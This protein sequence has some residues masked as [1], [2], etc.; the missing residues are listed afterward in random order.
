M[1]LSTL[2]QV[3]YQPMQVSPFDTHSETMLMFFVVLFLYATATAGE[4]LMAGDP[5]YLAVASNIRLLVSVLSSILLLLILVPIMGWVAFGMWLCFAFKVI[6]DSYEVVY[7]LLREASLQ[8][9]DMARGIMAIVR[10]GFRTGNASNS[11]VKVPKCRETDL[12]KNIKG[13]LSFIEAQMG[14]IGLGP[15]Q[16]I[17]PGRFLFFSSSSCNEEETRDQRYRK[18][19]KQQTRKETKKK[20]EKK[21]QTSMNY[22]NYH[23]QRFQYQY[24]QYPQQQQQQQVQYQ[25]HST[26]SY[27]STAPLTTEAYHYHKQPQYLLH[28]PPPVSGHPPGIP[29]PPNPYYPPVEN[30]QQPNPGLD[31]QFWRPTQQ[32]QRGQSTHKDGS[33]SGGRTFRGHGQGHF[34]HLSSTSGGHSS[35][36]FNRKGGQV[37]GKHLKPHGASLTQNSAPAPA[38]GAA[39]LI[40]PFA[41]MSGHVASQVSAAPPHVPPRM[42]W[43]DL[44]KVGCK[45]E[46]ILEQHKNGKK[47]KRKLSK[48][49]ELQNQNQLISEYSNL[50]MPSSVLKLE[51]VRSEKSLASKEAENLPET[52]ACQAVSSSNMDETDPQRGTAMKS[53][54]SVCES[55][56]EPANKL[57]CQFEKRGRGVKRKKSGAAGRKHART[58]V[59]PSGP[60]D[61]AKS[62]E[63]T[64]FICELCNVRCESQTGFDHHLAGKKH[65]KKS[66]A[67]GG[68]HARTDAGPSGPVDHAKSKKVTPFV[69][70]LCN[71]RCESQ[72]SFDYHLAGKKHLSKKSGAASGNHAMTDA[73]PDGLA[74]HAK[75]KEVTSFICEFCNVRCKSRVGLYKH[76]A[77]KKHLPKAEPGKVGLL[78]LYPPDLN[79]TSSSL[80]SQIQQGITDH[81]AVLAQLLAHVFTQAPGLLETQLPGTKAILPNMAVSAALTGSTLDRHNHKN[82]T[83][84]TEAGTEDVTT[85]ANKQPSCVTEFEVAP[86]GNGNGTSSSELENAILP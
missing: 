69:C 17:V 4:A 45:T 24:P 19:K 11:G 10:R 6:Y 67:S 58:D 42:A 8:V 2:L 79:A 3:K 65:L 41:S 68:K 31:A 59:G 39:S 38:D 14:P 33:G 27:S 84:G 71:V 75:S 22:P 12:P 50:Q 51:A 57:K 15:I 81:Q 25:I 86:A 52:V 46:Q 28:Q 82:M 30:R 76:L 5:V 37:G 26:Q 32:L 78:A 60:A 23:F 54:V 44:C 21:K 55:D 64:P 72:F 29:F 63:V 20:E 53:E 34:G 74:D 35:P 48:C 73:R 13:L 61:N 66:G 85:G 49:E 43:C 36:F 18:G 62:K 56:Q 16:C 1:T 9:L 47:H 7:R 70:E 40:L 80:I 77:A 83:Q